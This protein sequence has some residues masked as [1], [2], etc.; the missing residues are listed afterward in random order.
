MDSNLSKVLKKSLEGKE[1]KV[2]ASDRGGEFVLMKTILD[3]HRHMDDGSVYEKV[4][5]GGSETPTE[6]TNACWKE[7]A[8]SSHLPSNAVTVS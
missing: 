7:I 2:A 4:V 5:E 6:K 3:Q 1:T 8:R